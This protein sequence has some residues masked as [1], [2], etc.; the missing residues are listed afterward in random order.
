MSTSSAEVAVNAEPEFVY[1]VAS[2]SYVV[3]VAY[4]AAMLAS[5]VLGSVG[6]YSV[7]PLTVV[8]V[9]LPLV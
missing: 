1:A 7:L 3:K 9:I 2:L 8:S 5:S 4:S 6:V